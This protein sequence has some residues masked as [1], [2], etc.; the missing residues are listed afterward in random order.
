MRA[1]ARVLACVRSRTWWEARSVLDKIVSGFVV[2]ADMKICGRLCECVRDVRLCVCVCVCYGLGWVCVCVCACA[3]LW[4]C[5]CLPRSVC[6]GIMSV[7]LCVMDLCVC[8][9]VCEYGHVLLTSLSV[10]VRMCS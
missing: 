8:V 1:H 6:V 5:V 3:G 10:R 2:S 9:C 7:C 4:I